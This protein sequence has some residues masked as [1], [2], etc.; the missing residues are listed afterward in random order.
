MRRYDSYQ[1][2]ASFYK[3]F[4][5]HV[6]GFVIAVLGIWIGWKISRKPYIPDWLYILL[7]IWVLVLVAAL[8][9]FRRIFKQRI[10]SR[11]D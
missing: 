4:Q 5:F 11:K 2:V 3:R 6:S 9:R 10:R 8:I 7:A 1:K